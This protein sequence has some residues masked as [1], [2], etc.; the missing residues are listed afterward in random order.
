MVDRIPGQSDFV[1]RHGKV[2]QEK[3]LPGI[4]SISESLQMLVDVLRTTFL[5]GVNSLSG[6]KQ[7][8]DGAIRN[9]IEVEVHKAGTA[10]LLEHQMGVGNL[11]PCFVTPVE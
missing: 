1:V 10:T 6:I 4:L 8:L 3:T 11:H 2:E 5:I 7:H 9:T